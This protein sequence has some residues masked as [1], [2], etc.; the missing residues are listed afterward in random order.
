MV[1]L[2]EADAQTVDVLSRVADLSKIVDS[3]AVGTVFGEP[4]TR[5]E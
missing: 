3:A 1:Q 4:I 5:M 2:S